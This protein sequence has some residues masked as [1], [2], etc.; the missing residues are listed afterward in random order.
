MKDRILNNLHSFGNMEV[1]SDMR[2]QIAEE[3]GLSESDIA[4]ASTRH[5]KN[6][7]RHYS[8]FS[9]STID[10]F[11]NRIVR[12]YA[13]ELEL[14]A[15]FQIEMDSNYIIDGG[16]E[17][18]VRKIESDNVLKMALINFAGD[19]IEEDRSWNF[20]RT[21][22]DFA[23]NLYREES[24]IHFESL[25]SYSSSDL[26]E[27]RIR[28]SKEIEVRR[29][30]IGKLAEQ[31][32]ATIQSKG[33]ELN[34]FNGRLRSGIGAYFSKLNEG[35]VKLPGD[36]VH[37][38]ITEGTLYTKTTP[39]NVKTAIDELSNVIA[40]S[41]E[42]SVHLIQEYTLLKNL[43]R[44]LNG[45]ILLNEL[46]RSIEAFKQ[47]K[48]ILHISQFNALLADI[49][50]KEDAPHIYERSG[51]R[52]N[53]F[54]IDEFQDT[55]QLQWLN[56][57]PLVGNSLS[58]GKLNVV[59][60]DGKQAIYRFRNGD[61]LQFVSLP[62]LPAASREVQSN[63]DDQ[64]EP[65]F[66]EG[67]YRS[68][69]TLVEFNNDL[70]KHLRVSLSKT[71]AG[72]YEKLEQT[73][74][75]S[76]DDGFVSMYVVNETRN[77]PAYEIQMR[78]L[79][80]D[81]QGCLEDGY[82]LEDCTILI[83]NKTQADLV[84]S[85]LS[86]AGIPCLTEE[87]FKVENH[88]G[89][90]LLI[91]FLY[92]M[93]YPNEFF[94]KM[95][96]LGWYLKNQN[97]SGEF[98]N[99]IEDLRACSLQELLDGLAIDLNVESLKQQTIYNTLVQVAIAFELNTEEPAVA[100][101]LNF[102]F[103]SEPYLDSDLRK[104]LDEYESRKDK[105]FIP[106]GGSS[107][108]RIMTIHKSKGLEFP[109]VF[110]PC[111]QSDDMTGK[112]F[113]WIELDRQKYGLPKMIMPYSHLNNTSLAHIYQEAKEATK[114]DHLNLLYVAFTRAESR[115]YG[116][117]HLQSTGK[118][119]QSG[120]EQMT[121]TRNETSEYIHYQAGQAVAV[122]SSTPTQA[123]E[124]L[125]TLGEAYELDFQE[126]KGD[127]FLQDWNVHPRARGEGMHMLLSSIRSQ[128]EIDPKLD[129]LTRDYRSI[130]D[131]EG[132]RALLKK[133]FEH[134]E[135]QTFFKKDVLVERE[136]MDKGILRPDRHYIRGD[137]V[138]IL[139]FKTG[140]PLDKDI[141]QVKR[142]QRAF[143]KMGYQLDDCYLY[144]FEGDELKL[145]N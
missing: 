119:L 43:R 33:I 48:N 112:D 34:N 38:H 113:S 52:Y 72:I 63:F 98:L 14:P 116:Y 68:S 97:R 40:S 19:Q 23:K 20:E 36:S 105:L 21:L 109:I 96:I 55:S 136:I 110:L 114:M 83:R 56:L 115:I 128:E 44:N 45:L 60:G 51:V 104:F 31:F 10:K 130:V 103:K 65:R 74:Q 73:P 76:Y 82:Q 125:T 16:I 93:Q 8:Y 78:L 80:E 92:S 141:E 70:F 81:L 143:T 9:V 108:V 120:L 86:D 27:M 64:F 84:A 139:D 59:V 39:E 41:V 5:L 135:L 126:I 132:M 62:K 127:P 66:L 124:Y 140:S 11:Y 6:I 117:T 99:E 24:Y 35:I 107:G 131:S 28:W 144:Y 17:K 101:L 102:V 79:K 75:S 49:V 58:D 32:V 3:L 50:R 47:E 1:E 118:L 7:L 90:Q 123:S 53:H 138:G 26:S 12:F 145:V 129:R 111:L 85:S 42:K 91:H 137:K 71:Y 30:A 29:Q 37:K 67:N 13:D 142:Y 54:L 121:L 89:T 133:M 95:G 57:L 2:V 4:K 106:S 87:S 94:Y 88:P 22:R 134:R 18:M 15:D 61:V 69:A 100:T 77:D 46:R 25:K 122:I